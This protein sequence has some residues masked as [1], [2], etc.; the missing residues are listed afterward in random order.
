MALTLY[1][2]IVDRVFTALLIGLLIVFIIY[3]LIRFSG[4]NAGSTWSR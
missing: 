4:R 1:I 3:A 2:V